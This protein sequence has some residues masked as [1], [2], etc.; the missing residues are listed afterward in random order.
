MNA[1]HYG[2]KSEADVHAY[3]AFLQTVAT[4]KFLQKKEK[5]PFILTRSGTIGSGKYAAHWTGD[6]QA[7]FES[8][9]GSIADI[10]LSQMYGYKMVGADICGFSGNT[11][12]ELCARWYQLGSLYPFA[13]NHNS[14]RNS[15]QEPYNLGPKVLEAARTNLKLRY[16][17]LKHFYSLMIISGGSGLILKPLFYELMYDRKNYEDEV[18]ETQFLIGRQLMA[19][20][21]LEQGKT[22]RSVYFS[23]FVWYEIR[24]GKAYSFGTYEIE[25]I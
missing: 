8:L 7:T 22:S 11:T 15:D 24:T 16:S 4:Q 12:E 14:M 23:T 2:N 20:P 10:F 3:A 6:N 18:A 19:A 5:F 21:I 9:K 25:G 1:T 13:R 17:L